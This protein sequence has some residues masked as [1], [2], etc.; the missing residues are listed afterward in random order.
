MARREPFLESELVVKD[1]LMEPSL[2]KYV[3]V[4]EMRSDLE[5]QESAGSN[6]FEGQ[7]WSSM[8]EMNSVDST[9]GTSVTGGNLKEVEMEDEVGN[10][11]QQK[12]GKRSGAPSS[13]KN[14]IAERVAA[15][16]PLRKKEFDHRLLQQGGH[17]YGGGNGKVGGRAF[18]LPVSAATT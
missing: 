4:R 6:S 5:P 14:L 2:H 3:T 17:G 16:T 11:Q 13:G 10:Q 9:G 18:S 15:A 1:D 8:W 7:P 12:A